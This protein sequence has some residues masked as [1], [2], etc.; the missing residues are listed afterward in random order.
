MKYF[1]IIA[2]VTVVISVCGF[3]IIFVGIIKNIF[4]FDEKKKVN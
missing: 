2:I 1:W 3:L 4:N